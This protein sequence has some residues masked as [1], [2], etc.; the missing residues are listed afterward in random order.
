MFK[1]PNAKIILSSYIRAHKVVT[2]G[3]RDNET[4]LNMSIKV[5]LALSSI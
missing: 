3:Y 1:S 2:K 4:V 5:K